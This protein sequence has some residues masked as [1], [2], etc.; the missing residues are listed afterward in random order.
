MTHCQLQNAHV[1]LALNSAMVAGLQGEN[2]IDAA[3][4]ANRI[5]A[6]P[7]IKT[8]RN[9]PLEQKA[10]KVLQRSER[11]GRNAV[12]THYDP[13]SPLTLNA[14]T[15]EPMDK[16]AGTAKCPF[17]GAVYAAGEKGTLCSGLRH[18]AGGIGDRRTGV[19][20][21]EKVVCLLQT[22]VNERGYRLATC[23]GSSE[24]TPEC[25]AT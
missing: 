13:N 19:S 15:L 18:G 12:E 16:A 21:C 2:F 4:F 10:R 3:G 20:E 1:L 9:A 7:E 23:Q 11:E 24:S 8:P 17:C 14:A 25:A 22:E 5:L 6:N